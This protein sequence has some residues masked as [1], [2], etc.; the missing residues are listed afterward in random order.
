VGAPPATA[1]ESRVPLPPIRTNTH[2]NT[3]GGSRGGG[4]PP[5]VLPIRTMQEG[6]MQRGALL[7]VPLVYVGQLPGSCL[8]R[9]PGQHVVLAGTSRSNKQRSRSRWRHTEGLCVQVLVLEGSSAAKACMSG[10]RT[11][12]SGRCTKRRDSGSGA[13]DQPVPPRQAWPLPPAS[14]AAVQ[15]RHCLPGLH[16]AV[17]C[18][19]KAVQQAREAPSR[20]GVQCQRQRKAA[21]SRWDWRPARASAGNMACDLVQTTCKPSKRRLASPCRGRLGTCC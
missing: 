14:A 17:G 6:D 10:Q 18:K 16:H 15:G 21:P 12:Q 20:R 19:Q 11:W 9:I 8:C 1:G 4:S 7:V 13:P 2:H 3:A 5:R